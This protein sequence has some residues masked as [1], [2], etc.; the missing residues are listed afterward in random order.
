MKRP[1]LVRVRVELGALEFRHMCEMC[2]KL[3]ITPGEYFNRLISREL[4]ERWLDRR[5]SRQNAFEDQQFQRVFAHG[6]RPAGREL[7]GRLPR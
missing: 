4:R 2:V 7:L 5:K 6:P 3:Q 1:P